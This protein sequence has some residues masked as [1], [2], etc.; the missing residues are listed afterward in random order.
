[1]RLPITLSLVLAAAASL[2]AEAP[3][4]RGTLPEDDL[5]ALGP[6][7][8][9]SVERSPS[10]ISASI[11]LAVAEANKYSSAAALW[12]RLSAST[13]YLV[14]DESISRGAS[15]TAKGLNYGLSLSQP[16]FQWGAYRNGKIIGDLAESIAEK[17]FADAYRLLAV[18]IREQYMGLIEKKITVRNL[19]FSLKIAQE[20]LEAQQARFEAGSSS[21]ADLGTFRM[22]VEQAQLDAD[23]AQED[24]NYSKQV[25]LRLV[26]VDTLSDDS[27]PVD[28][29]HPEFSA[30]LADTVVT[31]F[32][33]QGVESTFQSEVYKMELKQQDLNYRIAS[34]NLLPKVSAAA[35]YN[36]SNQTSLSE[37]SISQVEVEQKSYSIAANWNIFDG[38]ATRGAKLSALASK[39]LTERQR[40]SYVDQAVDQMADMRKQ[41]GF[42]SRAMSIAEVHNALIDAE[43]KRLAQD[44][45][46]GYASQATIDAGVLTLYSTEFNMVFARGEYLGRW[47]EFISLAGIDPALDNLSPRYAR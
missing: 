7:L 10:T 30:G 35:S 36:Y 47:T 11:S 29:N 1:M 39:R 4:I 34:V 22:A 17:Q 18:A 8:K 23:R 45:V 6:L 44:K 2:S 37:T 3:P 27:I 41:L 12:P 43:V 26:G 32:V 21:Q 14:S 13:S 28:L 24:F 31:G 40:Q 20:S 38:F 15:S 9:E 19:Q 5:P 25:F 42:A 33:G 46:L 16:V